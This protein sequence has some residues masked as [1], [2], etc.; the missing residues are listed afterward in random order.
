MLV[1]AGAE[2]T[3]AKTRP[4]KVASVVRASLAEIEDYSR[5]DLSTLDDVTLHGSAAADTTHLLAELLENATAFS[6][7]APASSSPAP[8]PSRAATASPS[9][10]PASA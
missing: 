9:P 8:P 1:L 3:R 4:V 6:P 10:T 7:A 5:V 2:Q